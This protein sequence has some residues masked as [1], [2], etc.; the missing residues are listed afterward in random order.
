MNVAQAAQLL[1]VSERTV[2]SLAAPA[3][4]IPCIRLPGVRRIIFDEA[5]IRAYR[6]ASKCRSAGTPATNAGAS[7]L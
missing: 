6:E 2:Y 1:G 4:P 3:G 7:N 5:D